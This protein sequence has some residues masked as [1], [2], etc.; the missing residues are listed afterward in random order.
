MGDKRKKSSQLI[1]YPFLSP[2]IPSSLFLLCNSFPSPATRPPPPGTSGDRPCGYKYQKSIET[3]VL[4]KYNVISTANETLDIRSFGKIRLLSSS[5]LLPSSFLFVTSKIVQAIAH[6]SYNYNFHQSISYVGRKHF[7]Q[8]YYVL[9]SYRF[10]NRGKTKTRPT[11]ISK[12]YISKA[13]TVSEVQSY[14]TIDP[15]ALKF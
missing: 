6:C 13:Q 5:L 9:V 14:I 10:E 7:G 2:P 3:L 1:C 11:I 15:D 4:V 8:N 12:L